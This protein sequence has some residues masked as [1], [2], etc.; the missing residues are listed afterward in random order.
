M[1]SDTNGVTLGGDVKIYLSNCEARIEG[2]VPAATLDAETKFHCPSAAKI[3]RE[4]NF[5]PQ[6]DREMTT[7]LLAADFESHKGG[8]SESLANARAGWSGTA[9]SGASYRRGRGGKHKYQA[10]RA[11]KD[12][13]VHLFDVHNKAFPTGLLDRVISVLNKEGISYTIIDERSAPDPEFGWKLLPEWQNKARPYQENGADMVLDN[14]KILFDWATNSGKTLLMALILERLGVKTLLL[15]H[16]GILA[17]QVRQAFSQYLGINALVLDGANANKKYKLN[18]ITIAVINTARNKIAELKE[19]GFDCIMV[20]EAHR[21]AALSYAKTV[22]HLSPYYMFGFSGTAFRH[23][24]DGVVLEAQYG[25]VR[26][27]QS[28]SDM[29]KAG[30]SCKVKVEIIEVEIEANKEDPWSQVYHNTIVINETYNAAIIGSIIKHVSDGRNIA[31]QVAQK[32][33]GEL[34]WYVCSEL[35]GVRCVLV[36]GN[37]SA[38]ENWRKLEAFKSGHYNVAIGT[39]LNEGFDHDG[40][41][42][43]I[44]AA[45]YKAVGLLK[46]KLGRVLR[47]RED[48]DYGVFVDFFVWGHP[49]LEKH[50][51]SR[52]EAL[53]TEGFAVPI[54]DRLRSEEQE[55][56]RLRDEEARLLNEKYEEIKKEYVNKHGSEK[57]FSKDIMVK[58]S[59]VAFAKDESKWLNGFTVGNED[60][61]G[62]DTP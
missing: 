34:L 40:L 26:P 7:A 11:K 54:L 17:R 27:K 41:D 23:G 3:L 29:I 22:K 61:E 53:E 16:S 20:D 49:V 28:N 9:Q 60:F 58:L 8:P 43:V 14:P 10:D 31:V 38:K 52:C 4:Q 46:Q 15:T 35:E 47:N 5:D 25:N 57:G 50:S 33:Q 42:V 59:G 48:K 45:G 13:Y 56:T 21:S 30:H 37:S 55:A 19:F 2:D 12:N 6:R 44:N 18:P 24:T 1:F 32:K 62:G 39:V 51:R 36:D